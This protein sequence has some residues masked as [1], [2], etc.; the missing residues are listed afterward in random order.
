M[1][2]NTILSNL[3]LQMAAYLI[4]VI[5]KMPYLKASKINLEMKNSDLSSDLWQE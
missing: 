1:S 5:L 3:H 2:E 4:E